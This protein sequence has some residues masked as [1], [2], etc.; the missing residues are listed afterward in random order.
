MAKYCTGQRHSLCV[1]FYIDE[2]LVY[3]GRGLN[4]DQVHLFFKQGKKGVPVHLCSSWMPSVG[5]QFGPNFVF[6]HQCNQIANPFGMV[7]SFLQ[8][9]K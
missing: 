9:Y 3:G 2:V 4:Y 1:H 7:T 5:V 6:E 8:Y